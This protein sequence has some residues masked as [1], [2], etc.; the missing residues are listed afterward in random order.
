MKTCTKCKSFKPYNKFHKNRAT[1]DGY[2]TICKQ[3]RTSFD[4]TNEQKAKHAIWAKKSETKEKRKKY[5]QTYYNSHKEEI[6][7]SNKK[8]LQDPQ[9]KLQ[10]KSRRKL[11]NQ[12]ASVKA[13]KRAN[14]YLPATKARIKTYQQSPRGKYLRMLYNKKRMANL[15]YRL[16]ANMSRSIRKSLFNNNLSKN[17]K[18]WETL[19]NYS[20]NDL[21]IHLESLFQTGMTWD[22]YGIHG[23]HIDHIKPVSY[24]CIASLNSNAFKQCWSLKNLQPLWAIDN[25]R[26]SNH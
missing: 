4:Q 14:Y 11:Y 19:V 7:E 10:Q 9:K 26:K 23:W 24:F 16:S 1:N 21:K 18:H 2:H 17:G 3:C 5:N 12:K 22:N 15:T 6:I 25:I 8:Y 13:K 20:A